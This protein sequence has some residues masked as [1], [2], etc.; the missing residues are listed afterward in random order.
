M[1]P[2]TGQKRVFQ[3][4]DRGTDGQP[5]N[6][7]PPAPKGGGIT[8]MSYKICSKTIT[9]LSEDCIL[10][11]IY[12]HIINLD[13]AI[14]WCCNQQLGIRRKAQASDRHSVTWKASST[15]QMVSTKQIQYNS[16]IIRS[17]FSKILTTDPPIAC[18]G[19]W[20]IG[21]FCDLKFSFMF[22]LSYCSIV[23]ITC[24]IWAYD[25][26]PR[27]YYMCTSNIVTSLSLRDFCHKLGFS[28][29]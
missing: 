10:F 25:N 28:N 4:L 26:S 21:V 20:S 11:T 24:Y 29:T 3:A 23:W 18:P 12:S 7:M 19:R 17:I 2:C 6:I 14:I 8:S 1:D 27:L 16:I 15:H 22:C 5:E 9:P 13:M